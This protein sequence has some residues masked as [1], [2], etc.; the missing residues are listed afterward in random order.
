MHYVEVPLKCHHIDEVLL[1]NIAGGVWCKDMLDHVR[2]PIKLNAAV[3]AC[4][5]LDKGNVVLE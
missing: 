2:K 1:A 4:P 3:T 5:P